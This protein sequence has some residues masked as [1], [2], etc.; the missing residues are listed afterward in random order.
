MISTD[1]ISD[2]YGQEFKSPEDV[3]K[4]SKVA[5][6]EIFLSTQMNLKRRNCTS[7][8][9]WSGDRLVRRVSLVQT[10]LKGAKI[11]AS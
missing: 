2:I 7:V 6:L 11:S 1:I 9:V 3:L 8:D 10:P 5:I 4:F